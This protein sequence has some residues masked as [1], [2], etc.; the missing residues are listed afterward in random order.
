MF[1]VMRFSV[2]C[3]DSW[4]KRPTPSRERLRGW[5]TMVPSPLPFNRPGLPHGFVE[6]NA[7]LWRGVTLIYLFFGNFRSW[8]G[9]IRFEKTK[10]ARVLLQRGQS[11]GREPMT[12]FLTSQTYFPF[13]GA[14]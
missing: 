14:Q 8:Y 9:K 7:L 12:L 3:Q 11:G 5:P 4:S 1:C 10:Q 6:F 13:A 2:I